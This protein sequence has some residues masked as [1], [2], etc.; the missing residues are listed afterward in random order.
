MATSMTFV[1]GCNPVWFEV[2]LTAHAFD[3]TFF[4]F[5]LQNT[6]P[7]I[8]AT[9]YHDPQGNVPWDNPIQF[10]AN[11]TL[12]VDIFFDPTVVYR[13]EFRKGNTQSDPLIYLVEN[14]QATGTGNVPTDGALVTE[15]QI[16]NPQFAVVNFQSAITLTSVTDPDPI[17]IGGGWFLNLTGT[18]NATITRQPLNN[19]PTTLNPTN[20]PYALEIDIN[21]DWT[22]AYLSQRFQQNGML[23]ANKVVS[24]SVTA[25]TSDSAIFIS[26]RLVDSNGTGL[27][28]VLPSTAVTSTF[29]EYRGNLRLPAT[30]NPNLPPAAYIE[31]QL[32]LANNDVDI[33]LTSFQ[34]VVGDLEVNYEYLQDTVDR[35]ID[36]TFHYFQPAINFKP[37]SSYLVGWDFPLNPALANGSTVTAPAVANAY[38][39]DQTILYQSTVSRISTTRNSS[40]DMALTNNGGAT[41]LALI[42]YLPLQTAQNLLNQNLSVMVDGLSTQANLLGTVSLW[43]TTNANVPMLPAS[44]ITTL[45]ANGKPSAVAAE[46]FEVPR[47]PAFGTAQFTLNSDAILSTTGFSGWN[48]TRG[49]IIPDDATFF[50]IVVGTASLNDATMIGFNSISLVP[51]DIPTIPA[52][53]SI[54][55]VIRECQYYYE[56]S[57]PQDVVPGTASS[58]GALTAEMLPISARGGLHTGL[59]SRQFS[60]RYNTT[61]RKTD[62]IVHLYEL[63]GTIDQVSG[64]IYSG[65]TQVGS[66]AIA[67]AGNWSGAPSIGTTGT[68][69]FPANI[70]NLLDIVAAFAS[71]NE[72]FIQY[73]YTVDA[74]LG[75]L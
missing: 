61:K 32:V 27:G 16:S 45:D 60:F 6:I 56:K 7:Y 67:V 46:W 64:F 52:P 24:S 1:R 12:P 31:Y 71:T 51:G 59:V 57:Y 23:W 43:Y 10:L 65:G 47:D 75:I 35:Q 50:A 2:D 22:N 26:A 73:Q 13:L 54:D 44:L 72:A 5:V 29:T 19:S 55:E 74:R 40:G 20:A 48:Q 30:T 9:V 34:L 4:L 69:F 17:D 38:T 70:V 18:G 66:G 21:G 8:P 37:I 53:Q 68:A 11:G 36:H 39:W 33:L 63:T 14:Y 58:F 15:N 25:Q 3:D 62:P 41:Q 49:T 28:S 42:Q